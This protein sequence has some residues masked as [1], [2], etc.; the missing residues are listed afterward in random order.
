MSSL[1]FSLLVA[2]LIAESKTTKGAKGARVSEKLTA[3]KLPVR[4]IFNEADKFGS[5]LLP[6]DEFKGVVRAIEKEAKE[7]AAIKIFDLPED[8]LDLIVRD[9]GEQSEEDG[10]VSVHYNDFFD[11]MVLGAPRTARE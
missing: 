9:F 4:M 5:G 10:T 1:R 7:A 3:T 11:V 6:A 8:E 2:S